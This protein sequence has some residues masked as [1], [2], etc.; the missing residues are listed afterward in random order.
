MT[1]DLIL[2]IP[3]QQMIVCATCPCL[4]QIYVNK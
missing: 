4:Y 2:N 1:A 3:E